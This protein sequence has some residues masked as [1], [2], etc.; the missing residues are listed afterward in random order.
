MTLVPDSGRVMY[1][2]HMK[3]GLQRNIHLMPG[4]KWHEF[5]CHHKPDRFEHLVRYVGWYSARC[6]GERARRAVPTAAVQAPEDAQVVAA[7]ARSA[8]ARLIHKVYEVHPLE[9]LKC[10]AAGID[11]PAI[12]H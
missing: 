12:Y 3:K 5:L 8:W 9:C 1:R 4:A 2:F 11:C 7:H 10:G 6:R